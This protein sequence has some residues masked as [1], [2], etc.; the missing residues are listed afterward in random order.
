[1][2]LNNIQSLMKYFLLCLGCLIIRSK[3]RLYVKNMEFPDSIKLRKKIRIF[4]NITLRYIIIRENQVN[5]IVTIAYHI[6]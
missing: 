3:V 1:M 4:N 2:K 5:F 6:F